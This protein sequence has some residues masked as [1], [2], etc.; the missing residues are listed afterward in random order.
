MT[1]KN[2][3]HSL[4][5]GLQGEKLCSEE[6]QRTIDGLRQVLEEKTTLLIQ[7]HREIEAQVHRTTEIKVI[8]RG[9]AS[10]AEDCVVLCVCDM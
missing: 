3:L 7:K 2:E 4:E 6:R 10:L 9:S 5:L 1:L 8:H